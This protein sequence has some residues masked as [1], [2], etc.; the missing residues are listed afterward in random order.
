M[1]AITKIAVY[2]QCLKIVNEK[3]D[4]L[5]R[6]FKLY[7]ESAQN[8]TKST[9]GDKHDT[10]KAMMQMEQE[11]L[12]KQMS[13][14]LQQQ[15]VLQQPQF[16]ESYQTVQFGSLVHTTSGYYFIGISLGKFSLDNEIILCLSVQSPFAISML[17]L[18]AGSTFKF[19]NKDF[20]LQSVQ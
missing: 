19:N 7:S 3:L 18:K 16:K 8:E 2:E 17:G 20:Q 6:E 14:L 1:A 12:G 15:K 4:T 9:A 13:E 11:K 5:Q 10:G